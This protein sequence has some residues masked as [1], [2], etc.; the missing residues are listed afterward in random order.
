MTQVDGNAAHTV[1]QVG[2]D[3]IGLSGGA[4]IVYVIGTVNGKGGSRVIV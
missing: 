2:F 3:K 1:S 4:G